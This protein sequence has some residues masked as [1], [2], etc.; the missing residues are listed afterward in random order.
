MSIPIEE[1]DEFGESPDEFPAPWIFFGGTDKL[2]VDGPKVVGEYLRLEVGVP[3]N[4]GDRAVAVIRLKDGSERSIWL[5]WLTLRNQFRRAKPKPGEVVKV[6][7]KGE[8]IS[9]KG[10]DYRDF[11]VKVARD[12]AEVD[13]DDI[14][15]AGDD[16][17]DEDW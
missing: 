9:A 17:E 1:F 6:A 8:K 13:W 14:A 10:S 12:Q 15:Q 5:H 4:F 3:T 16:S 2:P 7:Y 11:K